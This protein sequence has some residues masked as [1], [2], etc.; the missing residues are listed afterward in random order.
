[1]NMNRFSRIAA[2]VF[3]LI[4]TLIVQAAESS[5]AER[6]FNLID[7]GLIFSRSQM[8]LIIASAEEAAQR[9][10]AGGTIYAVES[11][12]GFRLE[13][14]GRAGG[15]MCLK[16][17]TEKI[18]ETPVQGDIVIIGRAGKLTENDHKIIEQWRSRGVYV[19]AFALETGPAGGK[20][21]PDAVIRNGG[22]A[23]LTVTD[24]SEKKLCPV[25]TVL[26]AL[27]MWVWTGELT[28]ACTRLGKMPVHYQSY[29]MPGGRARAKKY[30]NK[31][32]HD[33]L[34]IKPVAPGIVGK[35]YLDAVNASLLAFRAT[36]MGKLKKA[37]RWWLSTDNKD[38][39]LLLTVGHMFP[40][41]FQDPRAPQ[42]CIM[43]SYWKNFEKLKPL[44]K[45]NGFVFFCGY[46]YGPRELVDYAV[47]KGYKLAYLTV[48]ATT[49]AQP[50][51]NVMYLNS[52]W[53]LADGSV[54]ISGY[55]VPILPP[56]GVV[57][58][59][60]YWALVAEVCET[61]E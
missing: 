17:L 4:S 44:F 23:G 39:V 46:Q 29:R 26:N 45:D 41:L 54:S 34:G 47:E 11:Q 5:P 36:E 52:W 3:L 59:V 33:D 49:P 6:Y 18:E 55:D 48:T 2:V 8:P 53:A 50:A 27:N 51:E 16:S 57:D 61:G 38:E 31:T 24:G 60:I 40:A 42:K 35:A 7:Q 43:K 32:F 15:L 21:L 20:A 1:M 30:R 12:P 28:A 13:A 19:V 37:A 10:V 56:S 9:L 14:F 22:M 58:A 25:D